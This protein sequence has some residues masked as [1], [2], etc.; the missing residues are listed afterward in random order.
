[1]HSYSLGIER[2]LSKNSALELRYVGNHATNLFQ[3]INANPFV[4]DLARDFPNLVPAGVTPCTT[5]NLVLGPGQ[6][7]NPALGR[8]NCNEGVI[9]LRSNGGFSNYNAFQAEFRANNLVKQL[10]IRAGYTFSKN[11]DNVSEI[12]GT[13]AGGN[14]VAF[15]Q[16]PFNQTGEYGFSGLDIPNQW[17][18]LATEEFPFYKDQH[19]VIGHILGGW[20]IS[21]NYVWASGQR[22]TPSQGISGSTHVEWRL[23]G[24]RI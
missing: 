16:N 20:S 21:A 9:R 22:Y 5:P 6:T 8:E 19:G 7:A 14:T 10:T 3:S 24:Q 23:S 17:T 1:M 18:I 15:A 2:E 12:F 4:A 11:L 13:G